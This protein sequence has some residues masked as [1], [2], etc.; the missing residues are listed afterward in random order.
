MT[1]QSPKLNQAQNEKTIKKKGGG[2]YIPLVCV[3][4]LVCMRNQ[5]GYMVQE[6][7]QSY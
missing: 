4:F 5:Y 2:E 3:C 1:K 7:E 6:E